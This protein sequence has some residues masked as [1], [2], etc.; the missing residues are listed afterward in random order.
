MYSASSW[1]AE[2]FWEDVRD[3]MLT[4]FT[5]DSPGTK[6]GVVYTCMAF[7]ELRN[8]HTGVVREIIGKDPVFRSFVQ[9]TGDVSFL[10]A[11]VPL[12][13][14]SLSQAPAVM[15]KLPYGAT[16]WWH[17]NKDTIDKVDLESAGKTQFDT[18]MT[19]ILRICNSD[20]L[21]FEFMSVADDMLRVLGQLSDRIGGSLDLGRLVERTR[22]FRANAEKLHEA[23]HK[24]GLA[25]G[26]AKMINGAMIRLSRILNPVL[27]TMK[28]KYAQDPYH[29][30]PLKEIGMFPCLHPAMEFSTLPKNSDTY[31]ALMK[32]MIRERNR[33]LDAIGQSIDTI[34]TLLA[35]L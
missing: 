20:V 11:G 28:G 23:S 35:R 19:S 32:R 29:T 26:Q 6:G 16:P 12:V 25:L 22:E 24:R 14:D 15:S 3:N 4:Y 5:S 31:R 10:N 8:F 9:K 21:P 30:L 7:P 2:N 1:Y 33:V 13:S 34:E 17:T 18:Y 27:Y